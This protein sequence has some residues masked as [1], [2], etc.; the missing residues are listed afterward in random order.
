MAEDVGLKKD[1][2]H[3]A[4]TMAEQQLMEVQAWM[5]LQASKGPDETM[6]PFP[7]A[8]RPVHGPDGALP[9]PSDCL[10]ERA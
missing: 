4:K 2:Q 3:I 9:S 6:R 8:Q 7:L 1:A 10:P 5:A